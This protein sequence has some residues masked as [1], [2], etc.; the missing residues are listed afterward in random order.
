MHMR[1]GFSLVELSIVLVILGLL[2]GGIL[3]GQS[4]IRAAELR[5]V[6]TEYQRYTTAVQSFRDKYLALP[7]DMTNATRFW[8]VA[9]ATP[10]TCITTASTTSATCDGDGDGKIN[11]TYA[12]TAAGSNETFR[13]WQHLANA[14]LIEGTY[15]GVTSG[16]T[17]YSGV[18][19]TNLPASRMTNA[20][21]YAT[22][23]STSGNGA[24]YT[25]DYGNMLGFGATY[26]NS[27][28]NTAV[29][30]PEEAWGIDTKIDDGKP[31]YGKVIAV[32]W[33][34]VCAVADD[35]GSSNTDFVASYKLTSTSIAC[36]IVFRNAF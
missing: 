9:H 14:G 6:V 7:G 4:L 8:G 26:A 10:A 2:T 34:D 36:I 1:R 16:S 30:K 25:M 29:L 21:W 5:S 3:A 20:G 12:T 32:Y 23:Y 24:W 19:G 17:S 11:P 22:G 15:T 33:N 28:P 18:I 35:G 27:F 13:F 31:A